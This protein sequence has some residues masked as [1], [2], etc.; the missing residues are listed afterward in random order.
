MAARAAA[1][2]LARGAAA[3]R[4]Q[5]LVHVAHDDGDG[6]VLHAGHVRRALFRAV[7]DAAGM[8]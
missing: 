6:D 4:R 1:R 2:Q 7:V 8:A 3:V 5:K